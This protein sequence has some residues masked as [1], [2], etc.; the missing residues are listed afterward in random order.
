MAR[1]AAVVHRDLLARPEEA[2]ELR[3]ARLARRLRRCAARARQTLDDVHFEASDARARQHVEP[4]QV[5]RRLAQRASEFGWRRALLF[6]VFVLP[7]C[8]FEERTDFV[9]VLDE[10]DHAS[11]RGNHVHRRQG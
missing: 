9:D 1:V 3:T 7:P 10:H 8:A 4:A 6:V 5:G 2:L 11:H